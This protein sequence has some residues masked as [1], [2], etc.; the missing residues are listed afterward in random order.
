MNSAHQRSALR[1]LQC[2]EST[3]KANSEQLYLSLNED[4][5][6]NEKSADDD[7]LTV[8]NRLRVATDKPQLVTLMSWMR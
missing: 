7:W 1:L 5:R 2:A 4:T 8:E 3:N 6:R